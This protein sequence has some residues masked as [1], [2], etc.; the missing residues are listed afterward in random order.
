MGAP[1]REQLA[2]NDFGGDLGFESGMFGGSWDSGQIRRARRWLVVAGALALI[3]GF[4]AILVPAIAS[5][6]TTIFVGWILIAAAISIGMQAISHRA[7]V[8]GLEALLAF[9]AGAYVLVFPLSGTVTLTFVL[10]VWFFAN[11][12]LSLSLAFQLGRG[13]AIWMYAISGLLA[14]I[15]GFLIVASLPSSA[16][17]AIGLL[18]GINLIVWGVRALVGARLLKALIG[19][20]ATSEKSIDRRRAR[21]IG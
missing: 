17:W 1:V 6:T 14:V 21:A 15:M 5:V 2:R 13:A 9:A 19:P 7:P 12:V 10:A 11:G 18:L 16:G 4:V 3:T 20:P 8:R